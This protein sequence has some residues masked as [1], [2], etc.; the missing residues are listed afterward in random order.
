MEES[1]MRFNWRLMRT[2]AAVVIGLAASRDVALAVENHPP[3]A[4]FGTALQFDG[5]DDNVSLPAALATVI[6]GTNAITIEYWFKGS[7]LQSPVRF[8]DGDGFIVAGWGADSPQ[9]IISTDGGT[10]NGLSVGPETTVENGQWHHLAMTWQRNTVNGFKSYLDG[11]LV[12]QR[13]SADVALPSLSGATPYLGCI[14]GNSEFLAGSLDEVRI[15]NTALSGTVVSN[16]MYRSADPTHP[17]YSNLVAYC[18]LDEGTGLAAADSVGTY[19]GTLQNMSGSE[20][21]NSTI[22]RQY[23]VTAGQSVRG[24]LPGSDEDGASTNG[25][26]WAVSFEIVNPG[27]YGTAT[28]MSANAFTYSAALVADAVDH[29][30]Y[31]LRDPSN[32]VSSV[33]TVDVA[34]ISPQPFIDITNAN[35]AV[36]DSVAAYT[37]GGTNNPWVTGTMWWTNTLSGSHGTRAAASPWTVTNIALAFG[38]NTITVSGTNYAGVVASDSVTITRAVTRYVWTNSPSPA[39]PFTNWTHAAHTIQDAVDTASDGDRVWVTNGVYNTGGAV[40]PGYVLSNR[41]CIAKAVS[42]QSVNGPSNTFIVGAA[43]PG[44]TNGPAAVRCVYLTNNAVL[45]GFT[46]TNGNTQTAGDDYHDQSGGGAFLDN[47]GL[48]SNCVLTGCS[49]YEYGGAACCYG[50]GTLDHCTLSGNLAPDSGGGGVY[51]SYGGELNNCILANNLAYDGGG[52]Y[53]DGGGTLNNCTLTGNSANDNGGGAYCDYGG[54]LNNCALT[55]NS[56]SIDGGGAYSY[57]GGTLNNCTLAGNSASDGGGALCVS[58]GTLNNCI[59]YFNTPGANQNLRGSYTAN[60]TCSPGL[61]GSGNIA[62]DPQFVDKDAG[63]YHLRAGS[64]CVDTG[65]NAYAVGS[66]D[67]DGNARIVRGNVDMGA[68]EYQRLLAITNPPAGSV[69]VANPVAAYTIS[70]TN[71]PAIIGTLTW[72]NKATGANGSVP[73]SGVS[74]QVSSIALVLGDNLILVSG[75]N[76]AG[77]WSRDSVVISR[78]SEDMGNSP[79]HYAWTNSPAPAWPYTNWATAAHTIQQAVDTASGNDTVLVTN[80]VYDIGG[81]LMPGYALTNRVCITRAITLQS[82]NG[83]SNTVIV[84]AG[85][86]GPGAVRC[87]YLTSNAVVSGFTLTNGNTQTSGDGVYDQSGGGALLDQ[88]GTVS[89]CLITSCSASAGGGTYCNKGGTVNN[90]TLTANSGG[91]GGGAFCNTGGTL[92]HCTLSANSGS[93]GGGVYCSYGG[94]LDNC[95]LANNSA[96]TGGGACCDYGGTLNNCALNTNSANGAGGGGVCFNVGGTLNNCTLRGNSASV[97]SG[98]YGGGG[99]LCFS[100]GTLNN[101]TLIDNSATGGY[102]GGGVCCVSGGT[103]NNC[104]LTTNLA[105]NGGGALCCYGGTLNNC[106]ITANS[107]GTFGGGVGFMSGGTLNNCALSANKA[108]D[109]GGGAYCESGGMLNN[110]TISGNSATNYAGG[111]YANG[112]GTFGNCIVYFNNSAQGAPN[113][114]GNGYAVEYSCSPDLSGSGNITNNPQFANAP[115]GK[116]RLL[117][118]SP[119]VNTGMNDYIQG[120]TDLDG[121]PRIIAGTVDMGAY[122]YPSGMLAITNPPGDSVSVSYTVTAYTVSGTN[123]PQVVGNLTWT[124][125]ATGAG[126]S[127]AA[128]GQWQVAGV[129][130]ARGDNRIIVSGTNA[131][132][133]STSDSVLI[134]RS[135]EDPGSSPVHYVWTNSP[136]SAWPYTNW[137]TAAHTIQDAVDTASTNDT[138]L[139]TN[140]VYAA[141]GA[142]TPGSALTSRVCIA[143]PITVRSVN[144]PSNTFIVGAADPAST[145]GP[146][147]V[148]CVYLVTNAVMSGF[149]LTNGHTAATGDWV[150]DR[151]GGGALLDH[152]GTI[153]N[154]VLTGCSALAG[155]GAFCSSGG[156]LNN[157]TISGSSADYD[158]GGVLCN[159]GGTLNNCTISGNAAGRGD[160]Y[161]GGACCVS[162]GTLNNCAIIGN[163][164]YYQGGGVYCSSG[165]TLNN[166]TISGNSATNNGG[167]VCCDS[168]GTLNNCIVYLNSGG[169]AQNIGG[170]GYTIQY[171][172]S[173][174]LSGSGN[175]ASDP[176]F[177]NAAAGTYRLAA[178]SPCINAGNNAYAQGATDLAGNPRIIDGTVDMGAYE[179]AA[180]TVTYV[181]TNGSSVSPYAT[182]ADAA[183]TIQAAVDVVAAGGTVWVSNGV[184]AAGGA[185]NGSPAMSN[186]VAITNAITVQ[187]VNGASVTCITGAPDP[188][189]GGLGTNAT[190]CVYMSA[191]LL[192]GFTLSNGYTRTDNDWNTQQGGGG[193]LVKG[194][195]II[196]NCVVTGCTASHFG[197]GLDLSGGDAWNCMLV[198]NTSLDGGGLLLENG[199]A[200]N[201]L[202]RGNRATRNGGGAFSWQNGLLVNCTVVSNTAA[203]SAGGMYFN[204]SGTN[205]NTIVYFNTTN[206]MAN[207]YTTNAGGVFLYSCT[208]PAASGTGNLTNNPL[209]MNLAAG[210]CRL[211]AGSP[212]MDTGTNQTWMSNAVDLNGTPRIFRDRVDLGAYEWFAEPSI[213]I[214]TADATV[215]DPIDS[216]PVEGTTTN[217]VVGTM[218]WTNA[219]SGASGTFPASSSWTGTV[220]L[221]YNQNSITVFGSNAYGTV[222]SDNVTFWRH[223]TNSPG[224][225]VWTNSASPAYPYTNWNMAAHVIQDAVDVASTGDTVWVTN[226]VYSTGGREV[227]GNGSS[228]VD[229]AKAVALRSVNGPD[230]TTIA[231]RSDGGGNGPAARRCVRVG[232]G[233]SVSGFMLSNGFTRVDYAGDPNSDNRRGG[234]VAL[235]S[236]GS[237]SN[238]IIRNCAAI[239]GA[240]A[241][242]NNGGILDR[243]IVR[244]CSGGTSGDGDGGGAYVIL[245]G[246]VRNCLFIRNRTTGYGGG[247]YG[248]TGGTFENCTVTK[249]E[250]AQQ[251]GGFV[252]ENSASGV[253]LRNCI[254]YDNSA[255]NGYANWRNL[256]SSHIAYSCTYP[257]PGGAAGCFTNSPQFVSALDW[258]LQSSSP[259]INAGTNAYA[260][261]A[262]DL[263][264]NPRIIGGVV[265]MGAYECTSGSTANGIPWVWLLKYGL[266]TDGSADLQQ[267][268]ADTFNNDQEYT[269]DTDPTNAASYFHVTAISNQSPWTVYFEASAG[270]AYTLLGVSNLVSGVWTNIPGA[271]PRS[272]TGG[273]DSLSDTNVPPKGPFYRLKVELP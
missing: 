222:A 149:T 53:C 146:A 27:T 248:D 111:V 194:G 140:G 97:S 177:A 161:G 202:V 109:S 159:A 141:G 246:V 124:N 41:V 59:V 131:A 237:V 259:C 87:V 164:A 212:C 167:G 91:T 236:G 11:T 166:C 254:I 78:S 5:T 143:W 214:N 132:G 252:C 2:V 36:W 182:W 1:G 35:A 7:R 139:V 191:G 68:Y 63:D 219:S 133:G 102:G 200:Y 153:S 38:V 244:D 249:N 101:C 206:G 61:S 173:P 265:D 50:G 32:A 264:G 187:S 256:T 6:G 211:Q 106:A 18:K 107:A 157:C 233:G 231:G 73:V 118:S 253:R 28:V 268:D 74:F 230:V 123:T 175:I 260:Q 47:G 96:G 218:W 25:V 136:A 69:S 67:L 49:G 223:A 110:C 120:A 204:L 171:T 198:G 117:A 45:S 89:N 240:G 226:G 195:S 112:G 158:G 13:N 126:G 150:Y 179:Y 29:F 24:Q 85:P 199:R 189:T 22:G 64:P 216:V 9:H 83:P 263:D 142:V 243:C 181:T 26:D 247:I 245:S 207:N 227:N 113:I 250:A 197:G 154:C 4:G 174:G 138:V 103:L 17:A 119:C 3:V 272:G 92:T 193:A 105:S 130:L 210:N 209:F 241:F 122:E 201:C 19:T 238:C 135:K 267:S 60:D 208:T 48:V 258:H 271:G 160:G 21:T 88:G 55:G 196:S 72:T 43:D 165:G 30:T 215:F 170:G 224:H 255:T 65:T 34:V 70:G 76:A 169:A 220:T 162:G 184:Y 81:A 99:A 172:C 71:A 148:R 125:M 188:I 183:T 262:T 77:A 12:A 75:T 151:T 54:T 235:R 15:W 98:S 145:N 203:T 228:R 10:D 23:A 257:I 57:D 31:R 192:A 127:V 56:A 190:R 84:G 93:S 186:R 185:G 270:R 221:I 134:S 114:N 39:S 82:V 176:L 66:A 51:C 232:G 95:I 86:Q 213:V 44:S 52:V 80:G 180:P 62:N 242:L 42:V 90:C 115:A 129:A 20:W 104:T 225:Y 273:A 229:L 178:F 163:S 116:Y 37:I 58:G 144:G 251:A 79:V 155:G 16:W 217:G 269:A 94:E 33:S 108:Y 40:T 100:G 147:A 168:G 152:G 156:A 234:G 137:A 128:S 261:G 266:A 14:D 121:W 239:Q 8:Q 205:L 46:L